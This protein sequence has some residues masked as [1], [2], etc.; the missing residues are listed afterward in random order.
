[1]NDQ[2]HNNSV[3]KQNRNFST[4]SS[5]DIFCR[6]KVVCD[7]KYAKHL[8]TFLFLL[9]KWGIT[10]SGTMLML[11][12]EKGKLHDQWKNNNKTSFTK[13]GN[14]DKRGLRVKVR[15]WA[16]LDLV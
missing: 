11:I 8:F 4:K 12:R 6:S 10:T 2:L 7:I 16:G 5:I 13:K 9:P 1:M 15:N 14:Y 3:R